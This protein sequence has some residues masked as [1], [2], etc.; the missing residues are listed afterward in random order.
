MA[1]PG[2]KPSASPQLRRVAEGS[3]SDFAKPY[4]ASVAF[5]K[6]GEDY[7]K[8]GFCQRCEGFAGSKLIL[9]VLPLREFL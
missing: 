1:L 9:K 6:T 8:L 5:G 4:L 3:H 2:H 7:L